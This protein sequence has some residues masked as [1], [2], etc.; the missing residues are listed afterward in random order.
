[1]TELSSQLY[2]RGDEGRFRGPPWIRTR[3]LHPA[4]L[5]AC[6]PGEEGLVALF[7]LANVDSVASI[8]TSDLGRLHEDGSLELTGRARGAPLRGCSLDAEELGVQ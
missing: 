2:A 7:D 6:R 5:E 1:M 3:V 8:V 4:T